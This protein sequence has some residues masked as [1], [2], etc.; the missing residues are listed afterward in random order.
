MCLID[1]KELDR[2]VGTHKSSKELAQMA[3]KI[4]ARLVDEGYDVE[5]DNDPYDYPR[6][7][8]VRKDIL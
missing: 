7:V 4:I 8:F 6:I 5:I 3:N 1:S 2:I